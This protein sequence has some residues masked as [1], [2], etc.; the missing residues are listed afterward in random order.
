MP[1]ASHRLDLLLVPA[2]PEERRSVAPLARLG[3]ARAW[4][5]SGA[6]GVGASSLGVGPFAGVRG[7]EH[8]RPRLF[9]NGLGGF[10]V[11]CPACEAPAARALGRAMALGRDLGIPDVRCETCGRSHGAGDLTYTPPAAFACAAWTLIDVA[12]SAL[13]A[14]AVDAITGAWGPWRLI[15]RRVA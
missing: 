5:A 2:D 6:P 14:E 3:E 9:A 4:W 1:F 10:H 11:R 12:T 15:A 13:S 7:E 8:P